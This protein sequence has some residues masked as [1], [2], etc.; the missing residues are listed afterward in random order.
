MEPL[1]NYF[2]WK[3]QVRAQ[4]NQQSTEHEDFP[5]DAHNGLMQQLYR[6][7]AGVDDAV[8]QL[9]GSTYR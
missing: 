3:D 4:L 7:G 6:D 9:L 8:S 5:L 1:S 2:T